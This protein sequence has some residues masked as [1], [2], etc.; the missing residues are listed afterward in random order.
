[1][2]LVLVEKNTYTVYEGKRCIAVFE[3]DDAAAPPLTAEQV[4][5][6]RLEEHKELA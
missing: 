4:E 2:R 3:L 1:M 6:L 5:D